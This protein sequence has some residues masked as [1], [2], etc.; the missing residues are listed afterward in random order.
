M[1]SDNVDRVVP[2][3]VIVLRLPAPFD[4]VEITVSASEI[5]KPT[6][7]SDPTTTIFDREWQTTIFR[8]I[9]QMIESTLAQNGTLTDNE[10]FTKLQEVLEYPY[11]SQHKSDWYFQFSVQNISFF[12]EINRSQ[13]LQLFSKLYS[14]KY[15][16]RALVLHLKRRRCLH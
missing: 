13:V 7:E 5:A 9:I 15:Q 8:K 12:I 16:N 2:P 4:P 10:H 1:S 11:I 6:I 3:V 14:R